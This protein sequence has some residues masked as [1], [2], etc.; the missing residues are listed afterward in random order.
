MNRWSAPLAFLVRL[1]VAGVFL[2]AGAQKARNPPLFALDLEAYRL[3]PSFVILPLAYYLPWLEILTALALFIP[4]LRRPAV[5]LAIFLLGI[6]TLMLSL[7]WWRG[8]QINCGCF[9]AAGSGAS[10]FL[11]AIG[12]NILL[13]AAAAWLLV[14]S[15]TKSGRPTT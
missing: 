6:F 5:T 15:R 9:G 13:S 1:V 12:R 11:L 2:W 7:A 14:S 8:L 4:A 10:D 3:L